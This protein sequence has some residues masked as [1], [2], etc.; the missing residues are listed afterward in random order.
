M[1]LI[2]HNITG[3]RNIKQYN[4]I[5]PCAPEY[6]RVIVLGVVICTVPP[7]VMLPSAALLSGGPAVAIKVAGPIVIYF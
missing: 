6:G 4:N 5:L 2:E 3:F 7:P 1:Y